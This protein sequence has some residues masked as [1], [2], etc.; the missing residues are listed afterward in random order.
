VTREKK[1]DSVA[2]SSAIAVL[3]D[4]LKIRSNVYA[5]YIAH[6][7]KADCE[8]EFY[9]DALKMAIAALREQDALLA[10]INGMCHLCRHYNYGIGYKPCDNCDGGNNFEWR[11]AQAVTDGHQLEPVTNRNGL[12]H[13]ESDTVKGCEYCRDSKDI[14]EIRSLLHDSYNTD[15]YISE[16]SLVFDI[17]CH[18]YGTAAI[19]FCPMC[20]RRLEEV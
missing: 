12:N 6:G 5:E 18:S 11:G 9:L 1:F 20:G 17:G 4:E 19:K 14:Y 2:K 16:N 13:I 10:E 8:E 7:G 15:V 3:E